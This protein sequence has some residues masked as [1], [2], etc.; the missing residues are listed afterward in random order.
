LYHAF[1]KILGYQSHKSATSAEPLSQTRCKVTKNQGG[2]NMYIKE[3]SR[4]TQY[5]RDF[6][7]LLIS[8]I[9]IVML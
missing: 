4:Q 2:Y 1:Q 8:I 5:R 7:G 6:Q 3:K 9:S